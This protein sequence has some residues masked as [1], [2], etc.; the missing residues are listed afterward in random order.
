MSYSKNGGAWTS[1]TY[2]DVISMSNGDTVAFS[3]ANNGNFSSTNSSNSYR[4]ITNGQ[5]KTSGN[6][7]SLL[8]FRASVPEYA[9][10]ALFSGASI[11]NPPQLPATTLAPYCYYGM[12]RNN[13]YLTATP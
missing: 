1:Y 12:F 3:G 7:M 5:L 9:F 10:L 8:N 4:F 2:N 6:I 11:V 13:P